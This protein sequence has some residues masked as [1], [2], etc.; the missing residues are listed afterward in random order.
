MPTVR[1]VGSMNFDTPRAIGAG[2]ALRRRL[3]FLPCGERIDNPDPDGDAKLRTERPGIFLRC[4]LALDRLYR[5]GYFDV[6]PESSDEVAEYTTGQDPVALFFKDCMV[7]DVNARTPISEVVQ[8][9]NSWADNH[10]ERRLPANSLGRKLR[11][12]GVRGGF[13]NIGEG[14]RRQSCRVVYAEF[15]TRLPDF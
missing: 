8:A 1:F 13:A 12:L 3:I 14:L 7:I 9:F 4:M 2:D 15:K 5:R 6:P 10:E 11:A